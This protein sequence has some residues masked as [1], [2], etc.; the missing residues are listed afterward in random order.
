[1]INACHGPLVTEHYSFN[2]VAIF[3]EIEIKLPCTLLNLQHA[4][5]IMV[6]Y[7]NNFDIHLDIFSAYFLTSKKEDLFCFNASLQWYLYVNASL[8]ENKITMEMFY[9]R[10][11][12]NFPAVRR[13][14]E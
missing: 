14:I 3:Y 2:E 9:L 7:L 4:S 5:T 6:T 1:M 8:K 13:N 11:Y 10:C 12:F